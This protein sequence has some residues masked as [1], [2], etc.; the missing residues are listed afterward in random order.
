MT[1]KIKKFFLFLFFSIECNSHACDVSELAFIV[2][3][4]LVDVDTGG[5]QNGQVLER[6]WGWHFPCPLLYPGQKR[7]GHA[8]A[9]L[10]IAGTHGQQDVLNERQSQREKRIQLLHNICA[11]LEIQAM[12][13]LFLMMTPSCIFVGYNSYFLLIFWI[14]VKKSFMW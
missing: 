8:T 12:Y 7:R 4:C 13:E 14:R 2:A 9:H 11:E 10:H 3:E 1:V 6:S 5:H